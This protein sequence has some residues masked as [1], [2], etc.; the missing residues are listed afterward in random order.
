MPFQ[1]SPFQALEQHPSVGKK[2]N[3][4]PDHASE[5]RKLFLETIQNINMSAPELCKHENAAR[6]TSHSSNR[7]KQFKKGTIRISKELDLHGCT[8]DRALIRLQQCIQ[9]AFWERQ[10]AVLVITGKGNNSPEGPVLRTA[11]LSWLQKEGKGFVAEFSVAPRDK[12]GSGALV[13]FL[14]SS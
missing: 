6:R 1:N 12:G 14:K 9:Q 4:G 13:I 10:Q 3:S 2:S 7:I 5:D 11:V 8:R